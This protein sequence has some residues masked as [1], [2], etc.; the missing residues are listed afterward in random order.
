[1][2]VAQGKLPKFAEN[3]YLGEL[4][5]ANLPQ[6]VRGEVRV[7]VTFELDADGILNVR[8]MELGSGLVAAATIRLLGVAQDASELAEMQARQNAAAVFG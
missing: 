2:R 1:M 7:E 6:G 5:L 3:A 8:A 4:V